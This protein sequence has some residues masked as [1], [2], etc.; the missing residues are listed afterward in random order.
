MKMLLFLSVFLLSLSVTVFAEEIPQYVVAKGPS[1]VLNTPLFATYFSGKRA[2]DPC[3]GVRPVEFV[4][5]TGTLFRVEGEERSQGVKLYRVSTN[6]YPYPAKGGYFVDAR[7]VAPAASGAPARPRRLPTLEKVREGLLASLGKRYVWGGNVR[8]GVP[9]MKEL[10][11]KGDLLDG[12]DCSGLLYQATDGFTPRNT[13]TL[14]SFGERVAIARLTAEEIAVKLKPLDLIVWKG[15][16]M[17]VLDGERIIE[18]TMGCEGGEAGVHLTP[19]MEGLAALLRHR[20]GVDDYGDLKGGDKGFV[21][22]RWFPA[23]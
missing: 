12:V 5:L 21:V 7:F 3:R 13:S 19:L 6:D 8:E 22:R 17:I 4:A 18:S 9:L 14:T 15:H 2:L 11:P 16:V 10:Y 23:R 20:K 1:P